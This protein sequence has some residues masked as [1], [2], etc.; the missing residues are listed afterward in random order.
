MNRTQ[1]LAFLLNGLVFLACGAVMAVV[2]YLYDTVVLLGLSGVFAV[3]G[4][5]WI[6]VS[7]RAGRST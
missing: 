7:H 4:A 2:G 1:R 3:S 6:F 5:F